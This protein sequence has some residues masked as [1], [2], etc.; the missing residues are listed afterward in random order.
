MKVLL[1]TSHPVAPP[2]NSG[3]KNL[4][5]T[6]VLGEAGVDYVFVGDR[7]DYSPWPERHRRAALAFT[8]DVPT[9]PQKARVF[10]WLLRAA[11]GVDAVHAV[12]TFRSELVQRLLLLTP[13]LRGRPLVVTCPSGSQLP[14][15]FLER[16]RVAVALSRHTASGL[17]RAGAR[18]VRVIPPGVDLGRFRPGDPTQARTTLGVADRPTL[19]FAGHHDP[20]GGLDAALRLAA[21]LRPRVPDLQLLLAL[22]LRPGDSPA[23]RRA[24][25]AGAAREMGLED[26]VLQLGPYANMRAALQAADVVLFQ[27]ATLGAKMELPMT[28]LEGLACGRPV[29]A[30]PLPSLAE[31]ADEPSP[32]VTVLPPDDQAAVGRVADLLLDAGARAQVGAAARALAERR[33]AAEAMVAAYAQVYGD[34]N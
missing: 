25:V 16:S 7:A 5:R 19:L 20:G 24:E 14:R 23:A 17:R 15:P 26:N 33:Y 3:D 13:A 10:A 18:D 11:P 4:A 22:R 21:R 34:L 28:L 6:L 2:W 1:L 31:L 12:V 32:A 8:S 27:P 29:L 30:S 9:A